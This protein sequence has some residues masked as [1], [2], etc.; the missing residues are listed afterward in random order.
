M[1]FNGIH[2]EMF[3][4]GQE[5]EGLALAC[6]KETLRGDSELCGLV[7]AQCLVRACG[8]CLL[9]R[10]GPY[11]HRYRKYSHQKQHRIME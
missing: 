10:W 2:F 5:E 3:V 9:P 7:M 8:W 4:I 11:G 6:N 1:H